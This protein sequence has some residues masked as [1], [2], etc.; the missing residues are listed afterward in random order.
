ETSVEGAFEE[1]FLKHNA[2][3]LV[4]DPKSGLILLANY[5]AEKFYGYSI[6]TLLQMTIQDI[7]I[8]SAEEVAIERSLAENEERNYFIFS[9]RLAS[10]IIRIVEVHSSPI[11][12]QEK[13]ALLSIIHDITEKQISNNWLAH[14]N[15]ILEQLAKE[16]SLVEILN[17]ITEFVENQKSACTCVIQLL[18]PD[19]KSLQYIAGQHFFSLLQQVDDLQSVNMPIPITISHAL[20]VEEVS[21]HPLFSADE[22]LF[23]LAEC[24]FCCSQPILGKED[25]FLGFL[26]MFFPAYYR[27]GFSERQHLQKLLR[28]TALVIEH[29]RHQ[30]KLLHMASHDIL[31]G[32]PNRMQLQETITK[33]MVKAKK[34]NKNLAILFFDIDHFKHINDTLGHHIGDEVLKV[35]ANLL[36]ETLQGESAFIARVSGDEFV[37]L[38]NDSN[39]PGWIHN[40]AK[41]LLLIFEKPIVVDKHDLYMSISIGISVF[42]LDG[43]IPE[44]LL[45]YAD[46]AMYTAKKAGR[47]TFRF[48]EQN[49][50]KSFI[51]N[52]VM[53]HDL[54]VAIEKDEFYL[55]YQPKVNLLTQEV[56][57]VEALLRWIHPELGVV[58]PDQFI[59]LAEE[60]GLMDTIG[61]WVL[62]ESCR[63]ISLWDSQ[64]IQIPKVAIN[65]SIQQLEKGDVLSEMKKVIQEFAIDTSRLEVEVTESMLMRDKNSS[66]AI[67]QGIC[68]LGISIAIDDFGTGYSSLGYLKDLPVTCL[69]ID[70]SFIRDITHNHSDRAITK[71]ITSLA[72]S[73]GLEVVAEGIETKAQE[74]FL[75]QDGCVMGQGY[76]YGQP[77]PANEIKVL[78]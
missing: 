16:V 24:K 50:S 19:G 29:S 72:Q 49:M 64:A 8:L 59:S 5:A 54:K 51:H 69:K 32:L 56:I 30:S 10:G 57:G 48:F 11:L 47:N 13:T 36:L 73:I 41:K 15:K 67:L 68:D 35:F 63:Q 6:A 33:E 34:K 46:I 40:V 20:L 12:Y 58:N 45:K 65:L 39:V 60:M 22:Q 70:K 42:P 26:L 1:A 53:G 25:K 76:L 3:M 17:E 66:I 21:Q 52:M 62:R 18:S 28:L 9:H 71:G 23:G 27:P 44:T 55:Y 74:I 2:V 37:V 4:I 75:L 78:K 43:E 38:L 7:N 77:V 61:I 14:Y 31:T